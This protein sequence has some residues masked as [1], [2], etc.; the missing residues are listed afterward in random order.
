MLQSPTIQ[1]KQRS[2]QSKANLEPQP[3]HQLHPRLGV[4]STQGWSSGAGS[5]S[6]PTP[7]SPRG[8]DRWAKLHRD[9]GNQAVLRALQSDLTPGAVGGSPQREPLVRNQGVSRRLQTKLTINT[10]GDQYEQEADRVADQVMHM[11]D[12]SLAMMAPVVQRKCICGGSGGGSGQCS[13]CAK[14]DELQRSAAGPAALPEAPPIVHDVLGQSGGPLDASTRAFFESRFGY[15]LSSVRVHADSKGA[16]SARAVDAL[17]YTVG[18]DIVFS[19]G[20]YAPHSSQ[21]RSLLAHEL[22][23]VVQQNGG[24]TSERTMQR[25]EVHRNYE[26][27]IL[28]DLGEHPEPEPSGTETI[29]LGARDPS[30]IRLKQR[31]LDYG[32][33]SIKYPIDGESDLFDSNTKIAVKKFQWSRGRTP[34]GEVDPGTWRMLWGHLTERY[35]E[36]DDPAS[37]EQTI[38]ETSGYAE[39]LATGQRRRKEWQDWG[40]DP[41]VAAKPGDYGDDW[42]MTTAGEIR[43]GGDSNWRNCNPGNIL[44]GFT[45][46]YS[47]GGFVA[48]NIAQPSG[49]AIFATWDAGWKALHAL[50]TGGLYSPKTLGNFAETYL[51]ITM[52]KQSDYKDDPAVY[53]DSV[54]KQTG[55]PSTRVINTLT[56]AELQS[57]MHAIRTVE[58]TREGTV[59]TAGSAPAF[60]SRAFDPG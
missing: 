17:A 16:K 58:G 33:Q 39:A 36:L 32:F 31:L 1:T 51:G 21:G 15:D 6:A 5:K 29:R 54:G 55:L 3:E 57:F 26:L 34:T 10:P 4:M 40:S 20:Q 27:H 28:H 8:L 59:I 50:L 41:P 22:T 37:E 14:K 52:G 42:A 35:I 24:N 43:I 25:Q 44:P 45:R 49:L 2:S 23:H 48:V 18:R 47:V 53:R 46:H 9:Y 7:A 12:P 19:D 38:A 13:E 60:Y 56:E 30:V 11:P